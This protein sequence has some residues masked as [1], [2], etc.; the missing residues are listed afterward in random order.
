MCGPALTAGCRI[1]AGP[2]RGALGVHPTAHPRRLSTAAARPAPEPHGEEDLPPSG[3]W[4]ESFSPHG[5][6]FFVIVH[7]VLD[8]RLG[9]MV[10][11]LELEASV[12]DWFHARSRRSCPLHRW[13][14]DDAATAELPFRPS[15]SAW[16]HAGTTVSTAASYG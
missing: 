4:V 14:M 15:L 2:A 10:P 13:L 16:R 9:H 12:D 6:G 11:S 5:F 8:V 7:V 1:L 3:V